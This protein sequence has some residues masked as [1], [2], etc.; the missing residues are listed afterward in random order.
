MNKM[1][2]E[3]QTNVDQEDQPDIPVRSNVKKKLKGKFSGRKYILSLNY[4]NLIFDVHRAMDLVSGA[5]T[6]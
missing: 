1:D 4:R 2:Q 5:K 6:P 3:G